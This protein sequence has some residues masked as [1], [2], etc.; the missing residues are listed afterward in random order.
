[1]SDGAYGTRLAVVVDDAGA[2]GRNR[3]AHRSRPNGEPWT[4]GDH[5]AAGLRLEPGVV[6][7]P[8]QDFASPTA[9]LGIERLADT[10]D[11]AQ[12]ADVVAAKIDVGGPREHAQRRRGRV[13]DR[14]LLLGQD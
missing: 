10:E 11:A 6:D 9:D 5:D 13:P 3:L 2:D 1:M 8:I 7:V 4:V 14:D 12:A